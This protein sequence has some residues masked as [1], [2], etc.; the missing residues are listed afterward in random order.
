MRVTTAAAAAALLTLPLLASSAAAASPAP[1]PDA[2]A[3]SVP[4]TPATPPAASST[5]V[6]PPAPAP[7]T[8]P[9]PT[10]T[11]ASEATPSPAPSATP[12]PGEAPYAPPM[13]WNS[14]SLGCSVTEAAVR[15]AADALA[16]LAPL[17][18]RHVVIDDCWLAAQRADGALVPDRARFPGGVEALAAYVHGKGLKLGVSLSAGTKACAGGGAGSYKNEAADAARVK[19]WGVDYVKYDWCNIPTADFPGQNVRQIAETLYPRMRQALG[20]GVVFAMN[21]EDGS[22]VPWLW[23]KGAGATTWRTNVYNRPIADTYANMVDIWEFNQLR[24]EY[25]GPGSWADP[26]LIQAGRGGMTE[27]EYRAQFTLWAVGAAPLMLQA[28]PAKAPAAV[29]ANPK[30]IAV[31]QDGLGVQARLVSSDGWYHVL[32]KPLA[33][34]DRAIAL[35][36]ESDRAATI[37]TTLARA[38]LGRGRHRV[39][40][41]W[42]GAVTSTGGT[43]AAQVPAHAAV[44]YRVG[45]SRE[46]APPLV[47]VEVDP[48]ALGDDRPTTLEPGRSGDIVTRVTNTGATGRLRDV[49]VALTAPDGWRADAR[50]S[51][52]AARLD[53]SET[54]TVTWSVTPPAGAAPGPY[55]LSATVTSSAGTQTAAASVAVATAPPSGRTYLSDLTWTNA[56]NHFGPVEKDT[57]NGERAAGDGKPITIQ[58]V[59]YAKGLGAHAPADIEYYAAGRC[60]TV[61]FSAG[62]DDEVGEAGSAVF[63]VWADGGRVARSELLT[64]AR[65]AQK[66]TADIRGARHVRLVATNG[67]DNATSDHA[68]FADAAI[69]CQ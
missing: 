57:S 40:E 68:D 63:E 36:N 35:F 37:S 27:T 43:I 26:D 29:V 34:G 22:T 49:R 5:S 7:A 9:A 39:E 38:G 10:P 51:T 41:L 42:T 62:I 55:A 52:R 67:G 44:L 17:G 48:G 54:F 25:A 12:A 23:A 8:P 20:D 14:R 56:K 53:G 28:D 33:N 21:N 61:E 2:P 32:A 11:P 64:G 31:N 46:Q 13:G 65:P 69:T 24:A 66:V 45:P 6:P 60:T 50:S 1:P 59:R 4:A 58:G 30:V 18:Y 19:A 16:P 47:T 15:Q 3:T